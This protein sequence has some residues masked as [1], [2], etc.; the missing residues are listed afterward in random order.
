M[1]GK[2]KTR[3]LTHMQGEWGRMSYALYTDNTVLKL[4]NLTM[5]KFIIQLS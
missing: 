5:V 3:N 1:W 2:L 4:R